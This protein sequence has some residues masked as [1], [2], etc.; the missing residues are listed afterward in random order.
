MEIPPKIRY[1]AQRLKEGHRV[2]R[3]TVRDFLGHFGAERR[4]AAKIEAIRDVL[5][6]LGLRTE[7][8]FE[9]AWIDGPIW[10]LLKQDINPRDAGPASAGGLHG[11]QACAK[12]DESEPEEMVLDST[13][14]SVE[15][16]VEQSES[17]LT[18]T[19]PDP[20]EANED[21][22]ISDP[23]FRIG[24]LP[25][26][27]KTL[28]AV[29][30]DDD[31]TRA[32]T[33]MLQYDFSQLPVM[34]GERELKG[35]VSWKSI[36]SRLS[37]ATKRQRVADYQEDARIVDASR[38]LFDSIPIIVEQG[39][40]LVRQRDRRITGIVTASDLSIQ[41]RTL[42]EP[43]LLLREIELQ[44][45][46][47]IQGKITPDDFA[48]LGNPA[49]ANRKPQNITDLTF[50]DYV[51]LFQSPLVWEKL[52]LN[53]DAAAL[54]KLLDDVRRIRNDV[55]HFDPDPMTDHELGTLK[56]T[57]RFLQDLFELLS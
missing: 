39:Y 31:I 44:V 47:L 33:L 13:P 3:I 25:A 52:N 6:S 18:S 20:P 51:R 41:F 16:A 57:V 10:L 22:E 35:V 24:S 14:S 19:L 45:R 8:D 4:G 5:D 28:I 50:G 29:N 48:F 40:V 42:T 53:I 37:I 34:Q 43:F 27:N 38:T 21:A 11:D 26:A 23:T 32:V 9:S 36:G 55:M 1:A 46:R 2:N 17:A 12:P 49:P 54:T 7:P 56:R 30:Q 15:Q